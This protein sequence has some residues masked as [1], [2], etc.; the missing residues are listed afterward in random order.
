MIFDLKKDL[1]SLAGGNQVDGSLP[2][3]GSVHFFGHITRRAYTK[4]KEQY[5]T[6]SGLVKIRPLNEKY[7]F[8]SLE[9]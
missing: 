5:A 9:N 6:D 3:P 4:L 1:T 7:V 8:V 2:A